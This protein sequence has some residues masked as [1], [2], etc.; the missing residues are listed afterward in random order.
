MRVAVVGSKNWNNY[1]EL[2]R[3]LTLVIED[4]FRE[5]P[6]D[7][8]ITFVHTGMDGAE[9]MVTEYC[10]KVYDYLRQKGYHVKDQVFRSS[11][12]QVPDGYRKSK[13]LEMIES[14]IDKAVIFMAA[15]NKRLNS[16]VSLA[17]AYDIPTIMVKG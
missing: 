5:N 9:N 17:N 2:M 12:S 7:S 14:G 4:H 16:F 10:G 3:Q 13:D 6:E 15:P 1:N 8:R 11:K